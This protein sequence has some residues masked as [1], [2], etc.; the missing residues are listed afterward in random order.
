MDAELKVVEPE[1]L[2]EEEQ[3]ELGQEIDHIITAHKNNRQEINR[4]VFESVAAMTK[5]DKAESKLA[6]KGFFSS[7]W[8]SITGS[9]K[10]LKKKIRENRAA[11]QYASQLTLQKLAE[12]NLMT[13]ELI[14]AVNNKMNASLTKVDEKFSQIYEGLGKF[15]KANRNEMVR[16]ETRLEKVERNVNLLTWNNTIEYQDLNGTDYSDLDDISKIVCLTRDFYEIT[17]GKWNTSDLLL[18][19]NAMSTVGIDPKD[20]VNY[21]ETIK[22]IAHDEILKERLLGGNIIGEIS[23]PSYLISIGCLKKFEQL[24][25]EESYLVETVADFM[26]QNGI[27]TNRDIICSNLT[28]KYLADKASVNVDME[29][30]S[31]DLILDLLYNLKQSSEENLLQLNSSQTEERKK[32]AEDL[33]K[34]GKVYEEQDEFSKACDCYKKAADLGHVDALARLGWLFCSAP[35]LE[36]NAETGITLLKQAAEAGSATGQVQLGHCYREGVFIYKDELEAVKW[37]IK[38]AEQEDA[39]AQ[40]S[41]AYCFEQGIGVAKDEI[42]AVNWYRRA[43]E[44][45]YVKAQL[46]LGHCYCNGVGVPDDKEEAETWYRK[47]AEQGDSDAKKFLEDLNNTESK[48]ALIAAPKTFTCSHSILAPFPGKIMEVRCTVGETVKKGQILLVLEAMKM[49][50]EIM[51]PVDGEITDIR[52]K[53]GDV[54]NTQDIMIVIGY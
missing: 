30:D 51:S 3:T 21:F 11:A 28:S 1:V 35:G 8:G 41:L 42:K 44:Q 50:N 48:E 10:R 15:F 29:V 25:H 6:N 20:K 16:L 45:G 54:V 7:L 14:T 5:A 34:Q 36:K 46:Q 43:A 37:Y 17:K 4:L 39:E 33:F 18:L 22:A 9:N 12:Q 32:Q 2:T 49:Q 53:N 23:D 19:K 38:S 52:V 40:Y 24:D 47:A 13:F 27:D 26:R 31:Y